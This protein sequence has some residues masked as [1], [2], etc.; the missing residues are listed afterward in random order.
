MIEILKPV[1]PSMLEVE[2][3]LTTDLSTR[4]EKIAEIILHVSRF[5]GKRFRPVLLLLSAQ[6]CGKL[7]PQ[8]LDLA[9]VVELVH[10]ATLIHDDVIDEATVRRHVPSVNSIW[11]REI[12]ILLGDYIWSRGFTILASMDSQ[13]STYIMSQTVNIM[14]EGELIQLQRRYDLNLSEEDYMDIIEK[15]T[16]SLCATSCRLGAM[17]AGA[18]RKI[19]EALT[20]Y[21]LKVGLAFQIVDDCLDI[22]GTEDEMGKSLSTDIKKGKLTLP[23]IKLVGSLPETSRKNT[24]RWIFQNFTTQDR[25]SVLEL[26]SEY[27][28]VEYSFNKARRYAE[29]AKEEISIL[30]DSEYKTSLLRLA[31]YV[32]SRNR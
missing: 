1:L 22:V 6:S 25:A 16:A 19:Q 21:G 5:K 8:H 15:K 26:F 27:E 24:C 23:L 17:F 18:N 3:R 31:D 32:V 10:I 20:R 9:V 14:C 2:E 30:P 29:E 11:G 4:H 28:A 13:L 7:V 12:S